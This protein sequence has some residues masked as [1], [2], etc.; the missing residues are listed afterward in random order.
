M[1]NPSLVG[2]NGIK[3]NKVLY[4]DSCPDLAAD[5]LFN[6]SLAWDMEWRVLVVG[7][8]EDVGV[9]QAYGQG[10]LHREHPCRLRPFLCGRDERSG[11]SHDEVFPSFLPASLSPSGIR[12]SQP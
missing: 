2:Y 9:N 4:G 11:W 5:S 1:F 7:V 12:Q 8:N 6:K 3:L 10:I